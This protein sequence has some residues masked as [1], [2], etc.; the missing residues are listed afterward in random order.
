MSDEARGDD[1]DEL[2]TLR[3]SIE[4]IDRQIVTLIGERL[5]LAQRTGDL[6]RE[7][8]RPI[9]DAAREAEVIRRAVNAAREL[10]VPQEATR[11]I[12]W[13]IVG[14]SRGVQEGGDAP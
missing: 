10:G 7:A 12:F 3:R 11:E 9:L 4:A 1:N 14:M 13:R 2:T 5:A 8:G 6:K